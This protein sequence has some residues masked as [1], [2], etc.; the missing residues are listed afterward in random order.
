MKVVERKASDE[1]LDVLRNCSFED[2]GV[3]LPNQLDRKMYVEVNKFL[4]LSGAKWNKGKK[5]HLYQSDDAKDNLLAL[6]DK[7]SVVDDKVT[8]Q[9][10]YTPASLA[11]TLVLDSGISRDMRVLEPSAGPV[12]LLSRSSRSVRT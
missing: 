7:G 10:F 3:V 5:K 2:D 11:S 9:A 12:R 6:I 4:E 8:R 1:V